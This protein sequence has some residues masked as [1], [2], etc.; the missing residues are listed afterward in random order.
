MPLRQ[1]DAGPLK[2]HLPEK[3]KAGRKETP[4]KPAKLKFITNVMKDFFKSHKR[5][6][7]ASEV[8]Q[9][10]NRCPDFNNRGKGH[11]HD[12]KTL[13]DW[14]KEIKQNKEWS[15]EEAL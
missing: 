9:L 2:D 5:V 13:R 8:S 6:P 3:S 1:W 7:Y 10:M 14:M 4:D 11:G 15:K 12:E